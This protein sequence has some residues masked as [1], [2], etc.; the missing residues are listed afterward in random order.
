MH[1]AVDV[2]PKFNYI[3]QLRP[4][5]LNMSEIVKECEHFTRH[6]IRIHNIFTFSTKLPSPSVEGAYW[7]PEEKVLAYLV[8]PTKKKK[9]FFT[10]AYYDAFRTFREKNI[11]LFSLLD[12][13]PSKSLLLVFY[14]FLYHGT[15]FCHDAFSYQPRHNFEKGHKRILDLCAELLINHADVISRSG[16]RETHKALL[17][18]MDPPVDKMALIKVDGYLQEN[19]RKEEFKR[20]FITES[21]FEVI[22]MIGALRQDCVAPCRDIIHAHRLDH[23]VDP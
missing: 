5:P 17:S 7:S 13:R 9:N 4:N 22:C 21:I 14:M 12:G 6:V 11:N 23:L 3:S 16:Y 18:S 20:Q 10:S 2:A 1:S 8:R 15:L 19:I